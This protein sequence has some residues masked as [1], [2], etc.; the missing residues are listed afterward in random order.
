M[1]SRY[2][3][4][5][6]SLAALAVF[7]IPATALAGPCEDR[8][9]MCQ[10]PATCIAEQKIIDADISC[11]EA[12]TICCMAGSSAS[13]TDSNPKNSPVGKYGLLNPL[14]RKDVPSIIGALVGWAGGLAGSLFFVYLIWGGVQWM[15]AGGD[16]K[17]VQGAQQRILFSVVGILVVFLSYFAIDAL[18]GL[19]SA[20]G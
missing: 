9:G 11:S 2:S 17:K 7:L 5:L 1:T 15:T 20:A 10:T 16:T 3:A 13:V 4:I 19:T 6:F 12:G 8:R 18:I 14:G